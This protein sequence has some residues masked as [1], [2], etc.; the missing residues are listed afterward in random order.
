MGW[1]GKAPANWQ[2]GGAPE[3]HW[4]GRSLV[5]TQ[6]VGKLSDGCGLWGKWGMSPE[7]CAYCRVL[8]GGCW[9]QR[10]VVPQRLKAAGSRHLLCNPKEWG[11]EFGIHIGLQRGQGHGSP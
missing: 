5:C 2:A 1:P 4:E 10:W 9:W 6:F 11:M 8:G 3:R 7:P